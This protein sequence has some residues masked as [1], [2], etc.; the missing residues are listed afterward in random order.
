MDL[1]L[2]MNDSDYSDRMQ[3]TAWRP[4]TWCTIA[5]YDEPDVNQNP[6]GNMETDLGCRLAAAA[7][8]CGAIC[9]SPSACAYTRQIK[10]WV[11]RHFLSSSQGNLT[12]IEFRQSLQVAMVPN[13]W[14]TD[15]TDT[16]Y[17]RHF[18]PK[19]YPDDYVLCRNASTKY[20]NPCSSSSVN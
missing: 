18:A 5:T 2:L 15:E 19:R 1:R 14:H 9:K 16:S 4:T 8:Q 3:T 7:G 6:S 20:S 13:D 11:R 10:I 17:R 12:T